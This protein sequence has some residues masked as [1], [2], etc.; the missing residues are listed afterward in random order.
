[1]GICLSTESPPTKKNNNSKRVTNHQSING[2][3]SSRWSRFRSF[4]GKKDND[5]VIHEHAIAAALLFQ[6]QNGG[7][8]PFDRSTSLRHVPNSKRHQP[9]TRSSSTRPRSVTDPLVPPQQLLNQVYFYAN[10]H[11]FVTIMFYYHY[12]QFMFIL[13][14]LIKYKVS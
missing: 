9:F 2:N 6:Q 10:Y 11:Y 1:M 14:F 3:S 12:M 7:V 8:L 5:A 13:L 4:S